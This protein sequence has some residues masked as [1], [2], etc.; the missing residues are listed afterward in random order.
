MAM[1]K[2]GHEKVGST[3]YFEFVAEKSS[4]FWEIEIS[5]REVKVR[6]GKIGA[7]GQIQVKK[8]E[9][10]SDAKSH[11]EKLINEKYKKGYVE[12][13]SIIT[14]LV[15]KVAKPFIKSEV[16][17]KKMENDPITRIENWLLQNHPKGVKAFGNPA[18]ELQ[19]ARAESKME[20]KFPKYVR[21][22]FLRH[23]GA[24]GDSEGL[25]LYG[26]EWLSLKRIQEEWGFWKGL[27]DGGSFDGTQSDG[28][29]TTVRRDWWNRAWIPLTHSGSG[30]HLCLDL[31]PGRTGKKGQIIRFWHDDGSRNVLAKS[32]AE[33]LQKYAEDLESGKY[34]YCSHED[35]VVEA[36]TKASDHKLEALADN[37]SR[38]LVLIFGK[39]KGL[40]PL[41][42]VSLLWAYIK[43]HGLQDKV[44]N[45]I[46]N[47]DDNLAALF[48]K[49]K[50]SMFEMMGLIKPHLK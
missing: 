44:N 31:A 2:S 9:M 12:P 47:A 48:G 25:P 16:V 36:R 24:R 46:I 33:I 37:H 8:F 28:D 21:E 17:P 10:L 20:I 34:I 5:G 3:R 45:Q 42:A 29:G 11:V 30:D 26:Y 49:R 27:L 41:D 43:K 40:R 23:N 14:M 50:V 4:R 38:A 19:I 39:K 15:K 32:F 1:K 18:T 35:T 22:F 6:F 13:T 7:E